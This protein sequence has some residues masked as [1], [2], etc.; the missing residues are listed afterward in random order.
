[1]AEIPP[2]AGWPTQTT[3]VHTSNKRQKKSTRKMRKTKR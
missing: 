3:F 1:M 2:I